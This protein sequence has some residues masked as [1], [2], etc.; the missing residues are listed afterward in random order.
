MA[1]AITSGAGARI[2]RGNLN[3]WIV[4]LRQRRDRQLAVGDGSSQEQPRHQERRRDWPEDERAR[5]V[6]RPPP[7]GA[8]SSNLTATLAPGCSLSTPSVT[9]TSPA[10]IPDVIAA[11][12]PSVMRHRDVARLDACCRLRRRRR[13]S[14]AGCAGVRPRDDHRVG[15]D[16]DEQPG[17]DELVR[18]ERVVLVGE[19]GFQLDRAGRRIDLVVEG[20]E[21]A[22]RPIASQDR[23]RTRRR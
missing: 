1:D 7:R 2:E 6:H 4:D 5:G 14:I 23:D 15:Q 11:S 18:K 16:F 13:M 12:S 22:G 20:T 17:V 21:R 3:R 8:A 10:E 19:R 9:T